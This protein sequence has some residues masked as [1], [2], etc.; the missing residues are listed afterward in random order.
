MK[1]YQKS[2]LSISIVIVLLSLYLTA[3]AGIA[4]GLEP[5]SQVEAPA[6]ELQQTASETEPIGD[7]NIHDTAEITDTNYTLQTAL[8]LESRLIHVYQETNPSVVYLI[9][10]S[11]SGS[12]FVYSQE[13]YIVTNNHVVSG[14]RRVEVVFANGERRLGKL[15]GSDLNSDLVVIQV[16]G[17]PEEAI[18]L[19]LADPDSIQVGQFA[20]AIGNPF[21]EQGSMTL[22]IIS[23]L[24]RSLTSQRDR[25]SSSSYSLPEV[26]QTDAPI[27]PG[28]SG[29][30]LL[31]LDGEVVGINTAIASTTGTNSGVGFAIP[32]RAVQ[33]IVPNLIEAGEY[34][35]PYIGA[36]FLS[37]ISLE[38]WEKLD[39]P[40]TQGAYVIA[41]TPH[42]PAERAGLVA[43]NP[44]TGLGGDLIIAIDDL[45]VRDFSDLNSYLVFNTEVGQ[46][47]EITILRDGD[48]MTLPLTLGSRP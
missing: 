5:Y 41:V 21:G 34:D 46:T 26:I 14:S 47:I 42:S 40:Q 39:L 13:G 7:V 3:C 19:R 17:L 38:A 16:E 20:I 11:G 44:E 1:T 15:I 43:A 35:Y 48:E 25:A 45:P 27:N 31:N 32:V 6:T 12:G 22:G 29:G 37:D 33:Q 28:N 4:Q 30:P 18:P 8:D 9:T 2:R 23:G 24:G 10:S 36:A